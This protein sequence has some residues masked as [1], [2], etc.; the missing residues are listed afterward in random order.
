[1]SDQRISLTL[2]N[3]QQGAQAWRTAESWAKAMLIAGHRLRL[4]MTRDTRSLAQ[5][6]LMWSCLSDLSEQVKWD[7]TRRLTDEGW[8]DY[9]T[10]HLNGQDLVPNMDGTGF[11]AIG[12][13]KSTSKMT[14]AEM[15]AVIDLAHAFG[16]G[17]GVQWSPTSL[18]REWVA[19]A[20]ATA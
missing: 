12:R 16:D 19:L 1:M 13:G 6:N 9:L 11:V 7:G 20:E 3:A 14:I 17:R 5:N 18:G 10:A 4:T 15:T 2:H 8:K